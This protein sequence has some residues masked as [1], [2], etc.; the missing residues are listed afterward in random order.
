M[1]ERISVLLVGYG[2]A[3]RVFHAP[4]IEV[5]SGLSLDGIVTS[6]AE[7]TIQ[8]REQHPEA[9]VYA[10][11]DEA[12]AHGFDL[13]V[14]ATPNVTHVPY[15]RQALTAGAHVVLDKPVAASAQEAADLAALAEEKER[16]LIPFQNRRWDSDFLTAS[17]AAHS[18]V[19]GMIHRFDSHID[20]MRV[21]PKV[22]WRESADPADLGG[23]LYDLGAHAIDQAL[24]L[25]GPVT[26]VS[27]SVRS[28]RP[29]DPTDDDVVLLLT[30]DS[31]AIS[32]V[33]VS[34]VAAFGDPR[35]TL[36]GTHGGFRVH[37][38]D[39]QEAVLRTG[40]LPGPEWGVE[41]A[42]TDATLR[43]FDDDSVVTETRVPMEPG[44]WPEF[45]RA[46]AAAVRGEQAPPVLISDVIESMR[47]MDAAR[48]AGATG[49][50]VT[51]DPP[52]G[53]A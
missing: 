22:G 18:G 52:A 34:Q 7:R 31:G 45:Y 8:A 5:T 40:T 51:L 19:L 9:Q 49:T 16:L 33:T 47:V 2:L 48:T 23:M 35:M 32:V 6:N 21:V 41:P 46:V 30:H 12:L 37:A 36:L 1:S 44:A 4:L 29:L 13:V 53:H 11:L 26:R 42:G 27:A 24:A 38:T 14:V 10:S 50:T 20:R 43:V 15:T 28:V 3:G 39:T 17:K 25:M